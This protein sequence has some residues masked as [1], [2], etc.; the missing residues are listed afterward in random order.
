MMLALP[1]EKNEFPRHA[2]TA[3]TGRRVLYSP[4]PLNTNMPHC[5]TGHRD[6]K[7]LISHAYNLFL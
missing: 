5:D 7:S 6:A 2:Q 1:R 4:M 3:N